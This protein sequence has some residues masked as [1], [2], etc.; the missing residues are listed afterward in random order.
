MIR[1]KYPSHAPRERVSWNI[2]IA[3]LLCAFIRHAPRER[4]SWNLIAKYVLSHKSVTLHVSV[5][6]EISIPLIVLGLAKSR[7]TWACELKF[8]NAV[9]HVLKSVTLHVSVWV[10]IS[11]LTPAVWVFQSRSTWACELKYGCFRYYN[12][13]QVVTLHVSVWV[14]IQY[15]SSS[16]VNAVSRS[17]WACELKYP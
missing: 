12:Q 4:V 15:S 11:S 14:E 9:F 3:C 2:L 5:W 8:V 16:F 6:V 10:E 17:T 7:S 13:K 1:K